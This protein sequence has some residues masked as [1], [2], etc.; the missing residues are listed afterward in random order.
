MEYRQLKKSLSLKKNKDNMEFNS[1]TTINP[2]RKKKK[3]SFNK[4]NNTYEFDSEMNDNVNSQNK[5]NI[6]KTSILKR[7]PTFNTNMI[8]NKRNFSSS[9]NFLLEK[10]NNLIN[11]QKFNN[12]KKKISF[13][14]N[15]NDNEIKNKK[16]LNRRRQTENLRKI[17]KEKFDFLEE[18]D[19]FQQKEM[20][21]FKQIFVYK[22]KRKK[23]HKTLK[24]KKIYDFTTYDHLNNEYLFGLTNLS[25][26]NIV[27]LNEIQKDL[28]KTIVGFTNISIDKFKKVY[29]EDSKNTKNDIEEN[30]N[31]EEEEIKPFRIL[32]KVGKVFDSLDEEDSMLSDF[33]INPNNTIL[34]YIDTLI[35]FFCIYH[36]V[37]IPLFLGYNI[38][39]CRRNSF[40]FNNLL[41]IVIDIIYLIDLILS[42][43]TGYI[44]YDGVLNTNL[45]LIIKRY[46]KTYFIIDF[47]SAIPFKTIFF[48]YDRKCL[49]EGYLNTPLYY[50]NIYYILI[51]LQILKSFK[52]FNQ[53]HN[54]LTEYIINILTQHVHFNQ[55]LGLY[56][57]IL[58]FFSAL[59]VFANLFIFIGKN[60]YPGWILTF[61]FEINDFFYLYFISIYYIITTVTT[62]GYGDIYC[63]SWIEKVYGLF[64]EIVGIV[65][66]SFALTTI[67]NYVKE[68]NDR[69]EQFHQKVEILNDIRFNHP[70]LSSDLYHRIYRYLKFDMF[71]DKI[72][73]QLILNSIPI[74]LKNNLVLNMYKPLINNFIFFK[75]FDNFDFVVN[76][77]LKFK[78]IIALRNDVLLKN[79]DYVEDMIFVKYGRLALDLPILVDDENDS[80]PYNESNNFMENSYN[81]FDRRSTVQL[82]YS[83]SKKS[84]SFLKNKT[85]NKNL[86]RCSVPIQRVGTLFNKEEEEEIEQKAHFEYYRILE[87]QKNEHFGDILM[88]LNKRCPLR[89]KVKSRKADLFYL[90]KKDALEISADYPHIWRKINKKSL[91]N[92]EQTKRLMTKVLKIFYK[93]QGDT[94]NFEEEI[95]TNKMMKNEGNGLSILTEHYDLE[96][97][98]TDIYLEEE[99][100]TILKNLNENTE[101]N[102]ELFLL[103]TIDEAKSERSEGDSGSIRK[104]K[105]SQKKNEIMTPKLKESNKSL[106]DTVTLKKNIMI[107]DSNLSEGLSAESSDLVN[108]KISVTPY[109][110][111]EINNEIYPY[112]CD[113]RT[114]EKL[115]CENNLNFLYY[116]KP[117][118]NISI[119]S[120]E[121]SFSI[122]SQYENIN[123]IS[124]YKY[125]KDPKMQTHIK[126][127]L[128]NFDSDFNSPKNSLIQKNKF[129]LF[130]KSPNKKKSS[131]SKSKISNNLR[132][133]CKKNSL[134]NSNL[135]NEEDINPKKSKNLLNVIDQNMER[136]YIN[137]NDATLFF[138]EF[139]QNFF[140]KENFNENHFLDSDDEIIK[141]FKKLT[142]EGNKCSFN[143]FKEII[144]KI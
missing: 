101:K 44:N 95:E 46:F 10:K 75:N 50:N 86:R 53:N 9:T 68:R 139:F 67:S 80:I 126:N 45:S 99:E 29:L 117:K 54:H 98:P 52:A 17:R 105:M 11:S 109:K 3:I 100:K 103:N 70:E 125:S 88:F 137:L 21:S 104:K 59:H 112:E 20:D 132:S 123:E 91:F 74:T 135:N 58:M 60:K 79:G 140:E 49:N 129:S 122:D 119:C 89:V 63:V 128:L 76:V 85:L 26:K 138:S 107:N 62:V 121:I 28:K 56:K 32:S 34:Y 30:I 124:D 90:N 72:D 25:N 84:N 102:K 83:L 64:M 142:N 78:P 69:K 143:K 130:K 8:K 144:K 115:D 4:L 42:F 43:F 65:A 51:V 87:I 55:Y 12:L 22:R 106:D 108:I 7:N 94:F 24:I 31:N 96:S 120:T 92:W 97:I 14:K 61:G 111:N 18:P 93:F 2:L 118:S 39:Y 141:K 41:Q 136:N 81:N 71:N 38:I 82:E 48:I 19:Y 134:K 66:Y 13:E 40:N 57:S 33:Y 6:T 114:C 27:E 116:F 1:E 35:V 36:I 77:I 127:L 131:F 73:K 15:K 16:L 133:I 5:I 110:P 47:L 37:Y 23:S 113:I